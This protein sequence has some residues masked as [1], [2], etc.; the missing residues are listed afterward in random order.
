M[1]AA[2]QPPL[3]CFLYHSQIADAAS[4]SC[5]ADIVRTARSFNKTVGITGMLVFDGQR[6]CQYI[7]GPAEPLQTLIDSIARDPRHKAFTPQHHSECSGE[8]RYA[9]WSMAYV[10]VD[11]D[12]PLQH[13]APL[14][15]EQAIVQLQELMPLLD[16]A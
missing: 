15:G 3:H 5:V 4:I 9:N 11:D 13:L 6:F 12:E 14:R 16:A 7:E 2:P 8:R 1:F 10:L